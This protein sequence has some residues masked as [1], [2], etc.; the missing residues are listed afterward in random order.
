MISR[1]G[2]TLLIAVVLL[3]VLL[4]FYKIATL[5]LIA[6]VYP[7]V[8]RFLPSTIQWVCDFIASFA[9]EIFAVPL[10]V[11][12]MLFQRIFGKENEPFDQKGNPILLSSGYLGSSGQLFYLKHYLKRHNAIFTMDYP[13][14]FAS[15]DDFAEAM[16]KK[17]EEI[18][19]HYPGKKITL[20]GHSM[21]GLIS[22]RYAANCINTGHIEKIITLGSPLQGTYT[23]YLG[24]G[25]CA[26][27]MRWGSDYLNQLEQDLSRKNIAFTNVGSQSDLIVLPNKSASFKTVPSEKIQFGSMGHL[28]FLCSDRIAT[29]LIQKN[30]L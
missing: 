21:G 22:A 6:L 18:Q 19:L 1:I 8:Q 15:I 29:F 7:T 28:T 5:A 10:V 4:S 9:K 2:Q 17:V 11:G 26:E 25:K 30:M 20:I 13:D 24:F 23:A 12:G 3:G 16:K 27:E 14:P